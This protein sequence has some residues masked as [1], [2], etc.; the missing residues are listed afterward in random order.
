MHK[1][2]NVVRLVLDK[3]GH[4]VKLF[5]K[6]TLGRGVAL[7]PGNALVFGLSEKDLEN[8]SMDRDVQSYPPGSVAIATQPQIS[9][10][11]KR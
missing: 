2:I 10:R 9:G 3:I 7:W 8:V 6:L 11:K 5:V 1:L 4:H